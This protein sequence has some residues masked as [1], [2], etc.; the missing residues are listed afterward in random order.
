MLDLRESV[1]R[2]AANLVSR[3]VRRIEFGMLSL[4]LFQLLEQP[5]EFEIRNLRLGLDVIQPIV[6]PNLG[7]QFFDFRLQSRHATSSLALRRSHF[8]A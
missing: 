2:L 7:P 8:P 1:N 5:I 6:P 3:T 4:D